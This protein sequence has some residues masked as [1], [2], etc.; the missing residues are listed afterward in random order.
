MRR[1]LTHPC[2]TARVSLPLPDALD[3]TWRPHHLLP[4]S[5]SSLGIA[6]RTHERCRPLPRLPRTPARSSR[7]AAESGWWCTPPPVGF[8]NRLFPRRRVI[9]P[10]VQPRCA[11]FARNSLSP[12]WMLISKKINPFCEG[13][14]NSIKKLSSLSNKS[15]CV[16]YST[17]AP[18]EPAV[19]RGNQR[20]WSSCL[21][22][23]LTPGN[24]HP[25]HLWSNN[26]RLCCGAQRSRMGKRDS[27][28]TGQSVVYSM[29]H[30]CINNSII[31]ES[32]LPDSAAL[33]SDQKN[34]ITFQSQTM[35]KHLAILFCKHCNMAIPV[36]L[37][38]NL[39]LNLHLQL[40]FLLK[41]NLLS[42]GL[43]NIL[44]FGTYT[45]YPS[46]CFAAS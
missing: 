39:H 31:K 5:V 11:R 22:I 30:L 9:V 23:N 46:P 27:D 19:Y 4:P 16:S 40:A 37:N 12:Y 21:E 14:L 7:P 29:L 42:R 1:S 26:N 13:K 8:Q 24:E 28:R 25:V 18:Y 32:T 44:S 17:E 33:I 2:T 38:I 41:N 43:P 10:S 3:S 45:H 15:L 20:K 34:S 35:R 6:V 36:N